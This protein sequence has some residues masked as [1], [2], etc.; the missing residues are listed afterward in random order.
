MIHSPSGRVGPSGPE[1]VFVAGGM[2][3][4][5]YSGPLPG[6]YRVRP[7]RREGEESPRRRRRTSTVV[8]N[9]LLT[10]RACQALCRT[11][12]TGEVSSCAASSL[13]H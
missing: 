9:W 2:V 5:Q 3:H 4:R 1:R 12:G 10:A 13:K 6:R 8:K 7:S 11:Y